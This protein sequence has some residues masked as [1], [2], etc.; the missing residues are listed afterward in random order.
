MQEHIIKIISYLGVLALLSAFVIPI[1]K[2]EGFEPVAIMLLTAIL[3]KLII[4]EEN[5]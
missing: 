2:Y 5:K 3:A 1:Y 4:I